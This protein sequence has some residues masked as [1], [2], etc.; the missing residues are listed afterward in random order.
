M[1]SGEL[2]E[3]ELYRLNIGDMRVFKDSTEDRI[4]E[5]AVYLLVDLSGSMHRH[6]SRHSY[7]LASP[8]GTTFE[9]AINVAHRMARLLVESMS[10]EP[11]VKTRVLAHSAKDSGGAD[12]GIGD[13]RFFRIWE[14]GDPIMRLNL[15]KEV[16]R[17]YNYDGFAIAWAGKLLQEEPETHKMLIILSD[18]LP[19]GRS[20][21]KPEAPL[22]VKR[23][24]DRLV[25]SGVDVM[26]IALSPDLEEAEQ[27]A[28]FGKRYIAATMP[29]RGGDM[30]AMYNK[31]L[32]D[33]ARMLQKIT[34]G[35]ER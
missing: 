16:G 20:Y 21:G 25:R 4:P 6:Q 31:L 22:H 2:D 29:Q 9:P 34:S 15:L 11:N 7:T 27:A 33:L 30:S 12:D 1:R 17:N 14:Q 24:V 23:V 10:R 26:Q 35:G 8:F 32:G 5:T 28:M 3:D 18:G 13:A 19:A